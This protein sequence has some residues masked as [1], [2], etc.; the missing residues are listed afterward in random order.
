MLSD[1]ETREAVREALDRLPP[2]IAAK[3]DNLAVI[4]ED[5]HPSGQLMGLYER[6]MGMHRITIYRER[7][8]TA[9]EV[10]RTVLHEIGHYFGMD[11]SKVRGLGL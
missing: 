7:N 3:L 4:V 1:D 9:E 2:D 10:K 5:D 11:E 6:R 8:P